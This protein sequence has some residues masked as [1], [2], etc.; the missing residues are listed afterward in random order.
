[1]CL[2]VAGQRKTLK[3]LIIVI[4]KEGGNSEILGVSFSGKINRVCCL[5]LHSSSFIICSIDAWIC[6]NRYRIYVKRHFTAPKE[7]KV[8]KELCWTDE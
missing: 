1:M 5:V 4:I 2:G 8:S 3:V 6:L 7:C